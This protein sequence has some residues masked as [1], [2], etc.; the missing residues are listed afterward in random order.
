MARLERLEGLI[1]GLE[2]RIMAAID[3]IVVETEVSEE[4]SEA[5]SPQQTRKTVL[6]HDGEIL[7]IPGC[8]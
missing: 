7:G 4:A 2:G 8:V 6:G 1:A 3:R 5:V